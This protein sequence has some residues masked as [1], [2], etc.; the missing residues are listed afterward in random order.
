MYWALFI[1][2]MRLNGK[3]HARVRYASSQASSEENMATNEATSKQRTLDGEPLDQLK[4]Y[5]G[6][7][8]EVVFLLR[9]QSIPDSQTNATTLGCRRITHRIESSGSPPTLVLLN[10][11]A[12]R[13]GHVR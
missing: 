6:Y 8:L 11:F 13:A 2:R 4:T 9:A 10:V 5:Q 7:K 3:V 1:K 12:T